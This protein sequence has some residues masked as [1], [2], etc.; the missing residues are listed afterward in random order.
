[1]VGGLVWGPVTG[2]RAGG[3]GFTGRRPGGVGLLWET[4]GPPAWGDATATAGG[5][6]AII[7]PAASAPI[8]GILFIMA[9]FVWQ[10]GGEPAKPKL[11]R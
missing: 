6:T 8:I 5:S 1:M 4:P 2:R 7:R 9:S 3:V 10:F 11:G